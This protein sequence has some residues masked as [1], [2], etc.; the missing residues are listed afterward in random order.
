MGFLES[1]KIEDFRLRLFQKVHLGIFQIFT[2]HIDHQYHILGQ[3]NLKMTQNYSY[4]K[5]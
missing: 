5:E 4:S 2:L 1:S 3:R